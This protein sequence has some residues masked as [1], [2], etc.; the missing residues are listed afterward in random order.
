MREIYTPGNKFY[1]PAVTDGMD[2]FHLCT[3]HPQIGS[4]SSMK[5]IPFR[6]SEPTSKRKRPKSDNKKT[7]VKGSTG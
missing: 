6:M 2:K 7:E 3:V 4:P 1:T 5:F